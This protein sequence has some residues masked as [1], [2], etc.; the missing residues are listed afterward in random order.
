[1]DIAQGARIIV[2]RWLQARRDDVIHF[3]TDETKTREAQAFAA[4]AEACGAVP[5]ISVLA[6]G[7]VQSGEVIEEMREIMSYANAI[8]GATNH[9]FIT[10]NAV[11]YALK[12]GARFLSLPLS[13]NNGS[14]L[15][16]QEFLRMDPR[17]AA[18]LGKPL[19]RALHGAD[20]VRVT[21]PLGTDLTLSVRGRRPGMFN[22]VAG[23]PGMCASASFEVYIP[24][25]ETETN[26]RIVLDGSLGYIGLVREP[27][28]LIFEHGYLTRIGGTPDGERL[29]SYI[30][31][32][33]D[34]EMYCA[35]EFGIG[36][37]EVSRCRGVSYIEDESTYGTFHIGFGRNLALGGEHEAAGHFDI[38]PLRPT[39]T[40]DGR[41][42]MRDGEVL[43]RHLPWR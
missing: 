40:V 27:L 13:T 20:T 16:E 3:V 28:E 10:T 21:T 4:A 11:A 24:P 43:R 34:R 9:S 7:A 31:G 5:K 26:G 29:R 19:L 30:E 1:M 32:F 23:R 15:L 6:S 18:S 38:V 42:V 25:V 12:R 2:E 8:V 37:N 39:I 36:L 35:A 14:S 33:G 41:A 17:R 22:G